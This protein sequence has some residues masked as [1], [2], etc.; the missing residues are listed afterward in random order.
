MGRI[1]DFLDPRILYSSEAREA[2]YDSHLP[3]GCTSLSVLTVVVGSGLRKI[4]AELVWHICMQIQSV[5]L[6][7]SVVGKVSAPQNRQHHIGSWQH[8][9]QKK[10]FA[11]KAL[12]ATF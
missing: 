8:W 5:A 6:V 12:C 9:G 2:A 4:V 3:L 1:F 11:G 7:L 10:S